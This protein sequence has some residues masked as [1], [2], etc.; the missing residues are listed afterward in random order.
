MSV[1]T[2]NQEVIGFLTAAGTLAAACFAY[3]SAKMSK[4]A[5]IA[6]FSPLIVP[7]PIQQYMPA[8][9]DTEVDG[10][11]TPARIYFKIENRSIYKNAFAKKI[12]VNIMRNE[13]TLDSL[14]PEKD[15]IFRLNNIELEKVL[16]KD[17][18]INY[19]D[20][21]GNKFITVFNLTELKDKKILCK[22]N[23]IQC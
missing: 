1:S 3:R 13:Y 15:H 18:M 20:I 9:E 6:Q 14:N 11:P 4:I 2:L 12:S 22:W 7:L 16:N 5:N 8:G 17:F 10:S 23:Y 19:E 21:L